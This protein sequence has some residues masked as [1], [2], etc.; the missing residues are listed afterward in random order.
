MAKDVISEM[1]MIAGNKYDESKVS[2]L[3][4]E[5]YPG[6]ERDVPDPWYGDEDAFYPVYDLIENACEAVVENQLKLQS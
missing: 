5:L 2:L 6:K 3:L 1:K 4:D